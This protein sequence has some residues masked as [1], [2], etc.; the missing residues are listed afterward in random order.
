MS[1][2]VMLHQ[3]MSKTDS[4]ETGRWCKILGLEVESKPTFCR[5]CS[6]SGGNKNKLPSH[7]NDIEDYLY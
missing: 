2:V 3:A 4:K 6:K 5:D 7:F 1:V